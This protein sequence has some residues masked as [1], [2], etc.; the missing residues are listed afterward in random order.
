MSKF[1]NPGSTIDI[2]Y[3][4][5]FMGMQMTVEQLQPYQQTL[6][7]FSSMAN[8]FFCCINPLVFKESGG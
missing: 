4:K 5:A 8:N 6:V 1:L 3:W 2:M 7:D